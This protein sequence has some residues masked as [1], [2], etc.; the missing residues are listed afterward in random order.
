MKE[1]KA[2]LKNE[3]VLEEEEAKGKKEEKEVEGSSQYSLS[4][5]EG[6]N[7]R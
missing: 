1:K 6:R 3:I 5:T 2:E 4:L 7:F